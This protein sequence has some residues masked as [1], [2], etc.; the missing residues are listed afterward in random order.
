MYVIDFMDYK[1]TLRISQMVAEKGKLYAKRQ[2]KSL[3]QLVEEKLI[4][5]LENEDSIDSL[6]FPNDLL[7][8]KGLLN[9]ESD[10]LEENEDRMQ[11]MEQKY[12]RLN[13]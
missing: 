12:K 7:S 9:S 13:D 8:I 11:Y 1:L 5:L 10:H 3:S 6:E 2:G 4:H